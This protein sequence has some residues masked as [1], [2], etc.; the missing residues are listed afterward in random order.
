MYKITFQTWKKRF[1][2]E[3]DTMK[4]FIL[5]ITKYLLIFLG[6]GVFIVSYTKGVFHPKY[7]VLNGIKINAPKN[8]YLYQVILNNETK[9]DVF[10]PIKLS[11]FSR[12]RLEKNNEEIYIF[13]F[14][15]ASGDVFNSL[16]V[17][18]W[19]T[20]KSTYKEYISELNTSLT[21]TKDE[22]NSCSVY[23]CN[24]NNME[25]ATLYFDDIKISLS[26]G[27]KEI[28]QKVLS[29][30]C[31]ENRSVVLFTTGVGQKFSKKWVKFGQKQQA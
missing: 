22:I 8:S 9:Q 27:N 2:R 31:K 29:S 11:K 19:K 12:Y 10:S 3:I 15:P 13:F 1:D 20:P 4:H 14:N 24:E 6:I 18:A 7:F 5:K 28:V 17:D 21:L 16:S 25:T 30:I 26:S 23:Y